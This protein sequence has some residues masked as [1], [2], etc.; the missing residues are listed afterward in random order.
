[1]DSSAQTTRGKILD[2]LV[3]PKT[4][5][6]D[7]FS[8]VVPKSVFHSFF[9]RASKIEL[10]NLDK[11]T[12]MCSDARY[13]RESSLLNTTFEKSKKRCFVLNYRWYTRARYYR[14]HTDQLDFLN[15]LKR[16]IYKQTEAPQKDLRPRQT[17]I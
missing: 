13:E 15:K 12:R 9:V 10:K 16:S 4:G 8:R 1:M 17:S 7:Q 5:S 11:I 2:F 3:K 6:F 14:A